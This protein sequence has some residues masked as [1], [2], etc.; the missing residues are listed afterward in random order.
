MVSGMQHFSNSNNSNNCSRS[1]SDISNNVQI[2]CGCK[3][4]T[5]LTADFEEEHLQ[6]V[7][8]SVKYECQ[9][10]CVNLYR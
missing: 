5:E 8:N 4:A 6:S 10:H 7:P 1:I 3:Y 2:H 9:C